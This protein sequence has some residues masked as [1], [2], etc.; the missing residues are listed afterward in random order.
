ME[1]GVACIDF[2]NPVLAHKHRRVSIVQNVPAEMWNFGNQ[3]T[4]QF[5]M[6]IASYK[7]TGRLGGEKV[8]HKLPGCAEG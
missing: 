3:S 2:S 8:I 4:Q 5:R 6:T 1:V 7:N